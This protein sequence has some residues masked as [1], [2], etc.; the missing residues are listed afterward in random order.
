[1]QHGELPEGLVLQRTT[2]EFDGETVPAGLLRAHRIATDV[3]GR[4]RVTAGA[5]R[6]VWE[7]DADRPVDLRAGDALV[8]PP[9]TYHHVEP[10]D[11]ARFLVEF[12]R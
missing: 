9:D 1:M 10:S 8:I 6:F 2:D 12:H 7:D 3:W 11:G 5:V 4:L